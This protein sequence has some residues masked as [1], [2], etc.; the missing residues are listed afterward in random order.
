MNIVSTNCDARRWY[1]EALDILECI[2]STVHI[3]CVPLLVIPEYA[4]SELLMTTNGV[5]HN[6]ARRSTYDSKI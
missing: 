6:I 5:S 3:A 1:G 2:E 4:H